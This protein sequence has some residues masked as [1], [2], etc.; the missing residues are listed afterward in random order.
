[1]VSRKPQNTAFGDMLTNTD[2]AIASRMDPV[3]AFMVCRALITMQPCAP[4]S[5][6]CCICVDTGLAAV[7]KQLFSW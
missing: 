2:I 1:M 3:R 7:S 6:F 4:C 5:R